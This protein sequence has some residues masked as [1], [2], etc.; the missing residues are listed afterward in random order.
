MAQPSRTTITIDGKSFQAITTDFSIMTEH[1]GTGMPAMGSMACAIDIQV[2]I[3][4][5]ANMPFA[6]LQ[7]LFNL[8]NIG[9][10]DKIKDMKIDFWTDDSR[11]DVVC[12]YAFQGWIS[13]Y[14]INS[15]GEA[16]HTLSLS[17]LP[18]LTPQQ[19]HKI[20]MSN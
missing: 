9:T 18:S 19:Y 12:S 7:S 13:R 15:S 11:S 17:L 16:N 3:N 1:D 10:R 8:A 2:D 5:T 14:H 4:D 20:E 6:T